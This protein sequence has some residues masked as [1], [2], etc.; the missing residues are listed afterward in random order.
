M[1]MYVCMF[2]FMHACMFIFINRWEISTYYENTC[3]YPCT[4]CRQRQPRSHADRD[5][6]KS[7]AGSHTDESTHACPRRTHPRLSKND[8]TFGM[9]TN[10]RP[11]IQQGIEVFHIR[12]IVHFHYK[13]SFIY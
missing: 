8:K 10:S 1:Y 6:G 11:L 12:N 3:T 5:I 4:S 9:N 13:K 7:R 2:V